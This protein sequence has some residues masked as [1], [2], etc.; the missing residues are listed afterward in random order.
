M[1]I[2][3]RYRQED[4]MALSYPNEEALPTT[5]AMERQ[6]EELGKLL[7]DYAAA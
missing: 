4:V 5:E 3:R 6:M 1:A 2:N 7:A